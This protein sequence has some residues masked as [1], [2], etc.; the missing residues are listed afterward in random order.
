V[1]GVALGVLAWIVAQLVLGLVVSR[2]SA[3]EA[4]YLL[5]GRR[6][7]FWLGTFS[8]FATWFGAEACLG[9]A[10]ASYA[11]GLSGGRADPFGY[12]LCL[13]LMGLVFA[14]PLRR[15]GALTL[16]DVFRT[17]FSSLAE[18]L[19]VLFLVPAS[20][21]WGAAQIRALG[22]VMSAVVGL[23]LEVTILVA[24]GVVLVYTVTGGFRADVMTDFVQGIALIVGLL[25]LGVAVVGHL[26]V[27]ET[28]RAAA[29]R[30]IAALGHEPALA[31]LEAWLVPIVGSIT[32]Q[33][34]AARVMAARTAE[35]ARRSA[36]AAGGMYLAVG[37][38][39]LLL[40]LL[41]PRLVPG[42][43]DPE[44]VIPALARAH[45]GDLGVVVLLGALAS[46]IFSTVDSNLLAASSMV[47]HNV[48]IAGRAVDEARRVAI[49]RAGVVVAGV[50]ATALA[51]S[52]ESVYGLVEEASAFGGGGMAVAMAFGLLTR[53]GGRN[54]AA[55]AML[56]S[57]VVQLGG[58]YVARIEAPL[59]LSVAVSAIAYVLAAL[60]ER[61]RRSP[62]RP[63]PTLAL[64]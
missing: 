52:R 61:G 46:A 48:V 5:G 47:S 26:G 25:V 23:P 63:A 59:T 57:L 35:L 10:G 54:A 11:Q 45:L 12:T 33:E 21:L 16:A 37:L 64:R 14:I 32:A 9:A 15:T 31:T 29:S 42:L 34:M 18:K 50:V 28:W 51:W 41:G 7:G 6:L 17:R 38:V 56:T 19:V 22:Q 13:L 40:G 55:A 39:P 44:R 3:T 49:A 20:V 62:P 2:R 60:V 53:F 4:D 43:D 27:A 8:L 30:P 1:S 58:T 24:A 36:L